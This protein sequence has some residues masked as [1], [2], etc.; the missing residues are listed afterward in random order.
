LM[1]TW[2]KLVDAFWTYFK[3]NNIVLSP[4]WSVILG[5]LYT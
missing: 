5:D 3:F 4:C 2:W 1:K